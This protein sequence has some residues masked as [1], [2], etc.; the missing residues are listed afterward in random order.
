MLLLKLF[1]VFFKIGLF[2]LGGGYAMIPFIQREAVD[3]NK[4]ISQKDFL[5]IT[6]MDTVTPGPIAVNM[7]TFVGYK[8]NGVLGAI[9]ATVGVVLPSLVLVTIIA[10]LFYKFRDNRYV[11]AILKGLKPAVVALI[12]IALIYLLKAKAIIDIKGAIIAVLVVI[13]ILIFKIHPMW[14]V[15]LSAI[16]GLILYLR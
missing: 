2:T 11:Q 6:A 10:A 12:I 5:E 9:V 15:G 4:W 14:L 8:V 13:G 7:A 1:A 16:A 3:I